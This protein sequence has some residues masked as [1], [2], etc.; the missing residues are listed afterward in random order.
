MTQPTTQAEYFQAHAVDGEL[1]AAQMMELVQLPEGDIASASTASANS[2]VPA[3]A[4][5]APTQ[6]PTNTQSN[7]TA[8]A[9]TE[10]QAQV[11]LAKDG[12]HTI[13]FEKLVEAREAEKHWKAQAQAAQD[14]LAALQAQADARAEA[15]KAATA[16]AE[17]MATASEMIAAGIKLDLGDYSEEAMQAGIAAAIENGVSSKVDTRFAAIEAKLSE[18]LKALQAKE[19]VSEAEQARQ[20]VLSKHPDA[21]SIAESAELEQWVQSK[22]AFVR[23]AYQQVITGGTP[24]QVIELLDAF[25]AETKPATASAGAEAAAAKAIANAKTRSPSSLSDIPG[26]VAESTNPAEGLADASAQDLISKF[27]G[28]SEK[29][30]W[31]LIEKIS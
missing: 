10:A 9:P 5:D 12:V 26:G 8:T 7:T 2:S 18:A 27:E 13:P 14:A 23:G 28:L 6:E 4:S 1:T 17:T 16:T 19:Q 15:G 30:R 11:I 20:L 31:E 24:A 21:A 3:A 29:A 22:P 25:K